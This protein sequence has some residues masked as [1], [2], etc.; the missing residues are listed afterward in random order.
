MSIEV[1]DV[2]TDDMLRNLFL[3]AF[4]PDARN[5]GDSTYLKDQQI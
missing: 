2:D 3:N 1:G 5:L 4:L